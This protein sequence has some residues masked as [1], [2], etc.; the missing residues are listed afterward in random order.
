[1]Q[2]GETVFVRVAGHHDDDDYD[3]DDAC[4]ARSPLAPDNLLLAGMVF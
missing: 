1:M 4:E 3:D 2:K